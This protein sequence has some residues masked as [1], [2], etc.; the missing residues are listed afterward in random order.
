MSIF[1][2]LNFTPNEISAMK[3]YN[4]R[5]AMEAQARANNMNAGLAV[6]NNLGP[7]GGLGFLLGNLGGNFAGFRLGDYLRARDEEKIENAQMANNL[8]NYGQ[9]L[10]NENSYP[11]SAVNS[12][13]G[14]LRNYGQ[15]LWNKSV[16]PYQTYLNSPVTQAIQAIGRNQYAPQNPSAQGYN[17][18]P[19]MNLPVSWTPNNYRW[20]NS[21]TPQNSP[22][23]GYTFNNKLNFWGN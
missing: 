21:Y 18:N 6:A 19:K 12:I 8:R 4:E 7:R 11:S 13:S 14:D 1:Q 10:M 17:F 20:N 5:A 23:Q 3:A 22:T 16:H 2:S 9:N 15:N